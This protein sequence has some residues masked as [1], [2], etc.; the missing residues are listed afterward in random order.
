MWG[1]GTYK[2][3]KFEKLSLSYAKYGDTKQWELH[4]SNQKGL[5]RLNKFYSLDWNRREEK[6]EVRSDSRLDE[7]ITFYTN[8]KTKHSN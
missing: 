5:R 4:F 2:G 3:E 8:A 6:W 7:D 1:T